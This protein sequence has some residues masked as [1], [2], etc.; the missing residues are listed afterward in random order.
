MATAAQPVLGP[1]VRAVRREPA[2]DMGATGL[3]RRRWRR[4]PPG[5]AAQRRGLATQGQQLRDAALQA[6]VGV[7]P[8]E[9]AGR[10]VLAIGIVVATLGVADLVAGQQHRRALR[11][12]QGGE[13]RALQPGAPRAHGGVRR[14]PLDTAVAA[15]VVAAAVAVAFAVGEV[16]ACLVTHHVAQGEA[17]GARRSCWNSPLEPANRC[18]NS[19]R[20]VPW[21]SQ[22]P[23]WASR[24]R[25]FHSS[26]PGGKPP[27]R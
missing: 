2:Q 22:K 10:V 18:A 20:P 24:K 26:Q 19:P 13:Q 27:S 21:S 7:R 15:E 5:A 9:P 25:S 17:V 11:Q 14:L 3:A 23:R 8:V 4:R 16:V 6:D 1:H 12:Q